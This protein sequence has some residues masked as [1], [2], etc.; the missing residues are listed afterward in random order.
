MGACGFYEFNVGPVLEG[1]GQV[2]VDAD[3]IIGVRVDTDPIEFY[4]LNV[5]L[6]THDNVSVYAT[7]NVLGEYG[8]SITSWFGELGNRRAGL[9]WQAVA[10][11]WTSKDLG[12]PTSYEKFCGESTIIAIVPYHVTNNTPGGGN[13]YKQYTLDYGIQFDRLW[14]DYFNGTG[15]LSV[16]SSTAIHNFT[17]GDP[18]D[19]DEVYVLT[20]DATPGVWYNV[21]VVVSDVTAWDAFIRQDAPSC[22]QTLTWDDLDWNLVGS[23]V[24]KAAFQFGTLGEDL[25]IVFYVER[26]LAG[27]GSLDVIIEPLTTNVLGSPP[28]IKYLGAA[29]AGGV[30]LGPTLLL[31][32]GVGAVVAIVAIVYF[33]KV[34]K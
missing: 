18:G 34:K 1:A 12:F 21:T 24:D 29:A 9:G 19:A 11:N 33:V 6:E 4:R 10:A 7:Y 13:E 16:G 25:N 31:V 28:P 27:E 8:N 30:D 22:T 23:T 15:S 2:A 5:T 20:L 32:G 17:L 26:D 3:R 14:D